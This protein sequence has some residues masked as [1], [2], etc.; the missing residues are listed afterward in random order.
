MIAEDAWLTRVV[1]RPFFRVGPDVPAAAAGA[2]ASVHPGATYYTRVGTA[3][4]ARAAALADAGFRVVDCGVTLERPPDDPPRAPAN[5]VTGSAG[6]A[7]AVTRIG[8]GAFA[9]SRFHL[10]PG[11]PPGA[12]D[13][14]KAEWARSCATGARGIGTLVALRDGAPA[15]FLSV[16]ADGDAY[17]IDLVAVGAAHRGRGLG[18]ALVQAFIARFGPAARVLRVGTQAA[19]IASLRLYESL[20]FRMASSAYAMHRHT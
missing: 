4:T 14:I 3:D 19:N 13:R 17:V 1:G 2:H 18:R 7:D 9:M 5:V 12:A 20:G 16:V 8:A 10:D 11:M 6:H 15:G